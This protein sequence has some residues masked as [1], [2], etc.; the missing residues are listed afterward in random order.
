ME[1]ATMPAPPAAAT[2]HHDSRPAI[3]FPLGTALLVVVIFCLS[4]VFACCYHW[5]KLRSLSGRPS[6]RRRQQ[7][8]PPLDALEEGRTQP[9]PP[10]PTSKLAP[11]PQENKEEKV[12]SLPVIMPGDKVPKF[13]AWPCPCQHSS[14]VIADVSAVAV[15]TSE[16]EIPSQSLA[17]CS[18]N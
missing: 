17:E 15:T 1:G 9:S 14:P 4:G 18:V 13:M 2:L 3:G 16:A 7:E 6:R 11:D 12:R 8:E 10:S 5:E